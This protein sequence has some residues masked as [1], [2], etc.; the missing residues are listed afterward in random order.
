MIDGTTATLSPSKQYA[1][2]FQR[3]EVDFFPWIL[4]DVQPKFEELQRKL[5][6]LRPMITLGLLR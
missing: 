3:V 6:W 4:W 1:S 5:T 2:L